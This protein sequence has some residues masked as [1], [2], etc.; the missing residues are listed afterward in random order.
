MIKAILDPQFQ[1][2][3]KVVADYRAAVAEEG[4]VPL[5]IAVER[6]KGYVSTYKLDVFRDGSGHDEES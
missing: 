6:N 4:G 2:M 5:V 1:P 3:V